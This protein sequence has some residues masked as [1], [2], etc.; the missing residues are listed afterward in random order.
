[1]SS[2][3]KNEKLLGEKL[4]N[5][6]NRKGHELFP[7]QSAHIFYELGLLYES[8]SPDKISLIQ[9]AAL[10]NAAL[11]RQPAEQKF[12]DELQ[13]LCKH[14]LK[15][16]SA[17]KK[18]SNLVE[19]SKHLKQMVA[20]MRQ[21]TNEELKNIK[22]I[23]ETIKDE[24]EILPLEKNKIEQVKTL[25]YQIAEQYS[26]IMAYTSRCCTDILGPPLCRFALVEMGSLARKEVTPYS[27][28][29]HVII[30][31]ELDRKKKQNLQEIYEYFRWY[32]V[33]FHILIIN[34]QETIIPSVCIS[35]LNDGSK[36]HG[37][38]FFDRNTRGISFD[39]MMPHACKF[40]LG[41]T[42]P[43]KKKS[44]TTELIKTVFDM[45]KYLDCG[46]D[47]K[48]GYKLADILTTTCFV[49]GNE[50][51]YQ[52]FQTKI[53]QVQNNRPQEQQ[54]LS[55]LD[56]DFKNFDATKSLF[57][58]TKS[59]TW[60]VKRVIYRSTSLFVSA[61]GRIHGSSEQSNFDII[62]EFA[63]RRQIDDSTAHRLSL[64]VTVACHIRL[65]HY[66]DRKSQDDYVVEN[67]DAAMITQVKSLRFTN[68]MS[69]K[70]L[71]TYFC[72]VQ[73]LQNY[74]ANPTR[75]FDLG[76]CMKKSNVW[77]SLLI[78]NI[79]NAYDEVI[80]EGEQ[81]MQKREIVKEDD[82]LVMFNIAYAY[83]WKN[84]HST[85]IKY[86]EQ[87]TRNATFDNLWIGYQSFTKFHLF[88]SEIINGKF[89]EVLKASNQI[90]KNPKF[91]IY[92]SKFHFI[93]G[94][95]HTFMGHYRMALSSFRNSIAE[96][97]RNLFPAA[98]TQHTKRNVAVCLLATR[99][100]NKALTWL[101]EAIELYEQSTE[102]ISFKVK[103][104]D[105]ISSCY[106]AIGYTAQAELY[107]S[108]KFEK[109]S[110]QP[111]DPQNTAKY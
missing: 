97:K 20:E 87:I 111:H 107:Q 2:F 95:A 15:C 93:K 53:L 96:S 57:I 27:D 61:L 29:E 102:S 55:Q 90:L 89:E 18:K 37:N 50:D 3:E 56:E 40:P 11:L 110:G 52:L 74:L 39:G 105:N 82:L 47:L 7:E 5:I 77:F 9:S 44:F 62:A 88:Y 54:I 19:I 51:L 25:Q 92:A 79:I 69:R 101:F 43:T 85:A 103:C 49:A 33:V 31:E 108:R 8:K 22:R 104:L 73:L 67:Y 1:M 48:N 6:C 21:K 30:L 34:L 72:D 71:I 81:Y 100:P 42:Q 106:R 86:F 59:R 41:R 13:R 60:N 94:L 46:E 26:A 10:L 64:L 84:N 38:W 12:K 75:Y 16:A 99:Q 66:M 65:Y 58:F 63:E 24:D 80:H 68:I 35:C 91:D 14:V 45:V 70:N 78:K 76:N 83:Q 23:P 32:S 28:F 98:I 109:L 17:K 36:P 4:R